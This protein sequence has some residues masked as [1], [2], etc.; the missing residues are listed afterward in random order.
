MG[1]AWR[2]CLAVLAEH[3]RGHKL[4]RLPKE[5]TGET[6][7]EICHYYRGLDAGHYPMLS[8]PE[9]LIRTFVQVV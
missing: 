4:R 6:H 3:P 1:I 2:M 8:H 7:A 5:V 9:E